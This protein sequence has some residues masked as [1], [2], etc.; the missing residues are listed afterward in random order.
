MITVS[1]LTINNTLN[2]SGAGAYTPGTLS[3]P[4]RA[5]VNSSRDGSATA[6]NAQNGS[7]NGNHTFTVVAFAKSTANPFSIT[8]GADLVVNGLGSHTDGNVCLMESTPGVSGDPSLQV[9]GTYTLPAALT[10]AMTCNQ[11]T[12]NVAH[13]I[14]GPGGRLE[15]PVPGLDAD[16]H[17]HARR[18]RRAPPAGRRVARLQQ[19]ARHELGRDHGG[20]AGGG[21]TTDGMSVSGGTVTVG[22][23]GELFSSTDPLTLT[24]GVLK[25]TGEV[26]GDV[27]NN[28]GTIRP[29]ASPG[30]LN[31]DGDF[32]QGSGGTLEIEVDGEGAGQFDVVAVERRGVARRHRHARRP[33]LRAR[34]RRRHPVP[35]LRQPERDV[36]HPE[37]RRASVARASGRSTTRRVAPFGARL[38]RRAAAAPDAGPAVDHRH[39]G[40]RPGR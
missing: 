37:R 6:L 16:P 38:G 4:F 2:I 14:I 30:T 39:A 10:N 27:V 36:R 33:G 3:I 9:E 22:A 8:D 11:G 20:P 26:K 19:R 13:L 25:G 7:M 35:H 15:R 18:R 21:I 12:D 5:H 32:T 40:E 17:A 29:G 28:G 24:G 34:E 23:G 31:V 1:T